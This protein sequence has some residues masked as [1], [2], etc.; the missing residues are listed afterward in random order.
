MKEVWKDIE[1]Y[2]GYYQVSNLGRV[3]SVDRDII[4]S[5][6]IIVKYTGKLLS[7]HL[8]K[9][10]YISVLFSKNGSQERAYVHRLVAKTFISNP[11][12]YLEINHKDENPQNNKVDNLEW[13]NRKYNLNYG[14]HRNKQIVSKGTPIVQLSVEGDFINTFPSAREAAR[15][16]GSGTYQS[17]ISKANRGE[18]YIAYDYC[19]CSVE[20]YEKYFRV[21]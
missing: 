19:W 2:E 7:L 6:G 20:E 4:Y 15:V 9:N 1:N 13:C 18:T 3:R 10:G 21:D 11:N 8:E 17:S 5:N 14:N 16:L 12:N